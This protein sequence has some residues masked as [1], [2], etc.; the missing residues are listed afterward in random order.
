LFAAGEV[1]CTG[2]HGANR[3]ASNSLLEGLVFGFRAAQ[4]AAAFASAHPLPQGTL[5]FPEKKLV[6]PSKPRMD[7]EKL[8]N[9]LRRLM[10][11]KVGLVR[12]EESLK[13][14]IAQLKRWE[15]AVQADLQTRLQLEV[16]NLIQVGQ[17]IA[18]SALWRTNSLG[19]HYRSD[20]PS[21][22][23]LIKK[24]HSR[25]QRPLESEYSSTPHSQAG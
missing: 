24:T 13:P 16:R 10:W 17:C 11:N 12:T 23:G 25:S 1:A 19:A 6:S 20:F 21:T 2:V 8:R 4:T 22:N 15:N 14:A 7:L 3:L 18:E 9:S 5:P